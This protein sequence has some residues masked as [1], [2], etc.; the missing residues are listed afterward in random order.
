MNNYYGRPVLKEPV[1]KWYIPAYFFTGGLAAGS[2]VLALGGRLTGRRR[3]AQRARA[4][5]VAALATSAA[6]LVADL[7]R[8]S[9]FANMLRVAKPSSPMSVGSWLLAAY[10][11]A[12]GLAWLTRGALPADLTAAALAPAVATYTG[13]LL[14]ATAVPAW[15]DAHAE[16]PFLFA[17]G[18]AAS[19]GGM[20]VLLAPADEA[21][22][23]R[24]LAVI[25]AVG[26][27][28]AASRIEH[29]G[30]NHGGPNGGG[31]TRGDA[32]RE[33]RAGRF[34]AAAQSLTAV[35]A[36][37]VLAGRRRRAVSA[38]GGAL[39]LGG[40]AA[41]RFAVF[42]AGVQSTRVTP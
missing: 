21:G 25:G 13:A 11:P 3:S 5:S 32:S 23:A 35:G 39:L 33:G 2:S 17:A 1:W 22:P 41:Q 4:V 14:A 24:R 16:L 36:A 10:G 26:E 27:L 9:R 42:H 40:A 7:G 12:T 34:S 6:F 31:P 37:L 38:V 30:P 28:A 20:G 19:A 29:R 18:A 15:R 8:P